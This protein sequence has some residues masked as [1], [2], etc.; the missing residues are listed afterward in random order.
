MA[1]A[2]ISF[3]SA[4]TPATLRLQPRADGGAARFA[5]GV[6]SADP[7][8]HA[9]MLWTRVEAAQPGDVSLV[10]QVSER[11]DFDRVVVEEN[12]VARAQFDNTVRARV[13]GLKPDCFYWF[14][15]IATD[16]SVSPTGRTRTA[17][18]PQDERTTR[19]ALFS[20]QHYESGFFTAYRRLIADDAA[21]ALPD[22]LHAIVHVGDYIY[23]NV[24]GRV[25]SQDLAIIDLVN[26]D[27]SPRRVPPFPSGGVPGG[28]GGPS[29]RLAV[30]L[31]DYRVLYRTYLSDPDLQA[32]RALYP[33]IQTWDD[34]E[35]VN[36]SWQGFGGTDALQRQRYDATKAWFEYCPAM[37]GTGRQPDDAFVAA[38]VANAP[39]GKAE[40]DDDFF[41]NEPNNLAAVGALSIYRR[42]RLG[43][44]V[45]L[46]VTDCRSYRG[47]RGLDEAIL[48][49]GEVKYP[50]APVPPQIIAIQAAGR[51]ANGG[52]PPATITFQGNELPNN[53]RDDPP[54]TMLGRNQQ[55]WLEEA[56]ATS[57]ATWRA[58]VTS[59]PLMRFGFDMR[60]RD[61]DL[62]NG[63]LWT[64][65]WDGYPQSRREL[66]DHIVKRGY[67]NVVSLTGDRHAHFA[68]CVRADYDDTASRD[69]F[70]EFVCAG[71]SAYCR[72]KAQS[73]SFGRDAE[74]IRRSAIETEP[75]HYHYKLAPTLNAWMIAGGEAADALGPRLDV[76]AANRAARHDV[77]THIS[78]A[79]TDAYGYT[80][81]SFSEGHV[82]AE[83]VTLREPLDQTFESLRRVR[84]SVGHGDGQAWP[85]PQ[86][87]AVEGEPPLMGLR[88]LMRKG[89]DRA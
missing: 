10:L 59:T 35:F 47:P 7:H 8:P 21:L 56:L 57:E 29:S 70:P 39:A 19:L 68:G 26:P 64:D 4:C 73:L 24:G 38:E 16:G 23:D 51:E 55:A 60:F 77:N 15:F 6:A 52:S 78:Y 50:A 74:L 5:Q 33:F 67:D 48:D 14:R 12:V 25:P 37:L 31:E 82:K 20:C 41:V 53:R 61:P 89:G 63:L 18:L 49:T 43:K 86:L 58:L 85:I 80:V 1:G 65:G 66:V 45:D 72:A 22:Q 2:G 13:E 42:L 75:G 76:A 9:V 17:P 3:L 40:A 87:D 62:P 84:F 46:I 28:P 54:T 30:T 69:T 44:H 27:G 32:A 81:L 79:D 36:D 71:A 34:H 83:F 11:A 88:Q